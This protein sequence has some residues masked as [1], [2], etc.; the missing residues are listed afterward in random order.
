HGISQAPVKRAPLEILATVGGPSVVGPI[1]EESTQKCKLRLLH[2]NCVGCS[3]V[4]DDLPLARFGI[5]DG[6]RV[7]IARA[8]E[9]DAE[10]LV[11]GNERGARL[12]IGG[13][14][15]PSEGVLFGA[16]FS[17]PPVGVQAVMDAKW[18]H[19]DPCQALA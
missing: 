4:H 11:R 1:R 16:V 19:R 10:L 2:S 9:L 5:Q 13:K 15:V 3:M 8:A 17:P 12:P 7:L 6:R 14:P 18:R